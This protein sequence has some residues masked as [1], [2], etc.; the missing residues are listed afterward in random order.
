M[1][2]KDEYILKRRRVCFLTIK[3]NE[4]EGKYFHN[5][6]LS[7]MAKKIIFKFSKL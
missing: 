4:E 2:Y 6:Y 7:P 5:W 3:T 1:K